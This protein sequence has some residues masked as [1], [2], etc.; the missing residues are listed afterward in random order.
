MNDETARGMLENTTY[1]P[2]PKFNKPEKNKEARDCVCVC[3]CLAVR[4][5]HPQT[6]IACAMQENTTKVDTKEGVPVPKPKKKA[7]SLP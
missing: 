4:S 1:T 2:L 5:Q 7:Q 6:H 3:V